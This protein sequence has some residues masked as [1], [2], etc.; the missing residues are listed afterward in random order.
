MGVSCSIFINLITSGEGNAGFMEIGSFSSASKSS[1]SVLG[2]NHP[3]FGDS[4]GMPYPAN[5]AAAIEA[6]IEY[7]THELG[8]LHSDII[9]YSWSIGGFDACYA[10]IKYPNLKGLYLDATFDDVMP[11]ADHIMP[12]ALKTITHRTIR[13][14]WNLDNLSYLKK[15]DG[16]VTIL[17]RNRDEI[18]QSDPSNVSQNRANVL[19]SEFLRGGSRRFHS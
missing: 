17:R 19:L 14:I 4:T 18:M 2:Y 11:L 12:P 1:F 10:G 6:V 16:P 8:F 3:G 7:A 13:N 5:N 9:I 15:F